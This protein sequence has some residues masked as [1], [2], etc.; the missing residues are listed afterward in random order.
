MTPAG[1]LEDVGQKGG[2][3]TRDHRDEGERGGEL[4]QQ[5]R[6]AGEGARTRRVDDHGREGPVEIEEQ[7]AALRIGGQ[8]L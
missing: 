3:P 2:G 6:H 8:W 4:G 7:C 1:R 5:G